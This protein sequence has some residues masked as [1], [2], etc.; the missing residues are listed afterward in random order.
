MRMFVLLSLMG[1]KLSRTQTFWR[2]LPRHACGLYWSGR[3]PAT[4]VHQQ[5]Q[6][7]PLRQVYPV[8]CLVMGSSHDSDSCCC[9]TALCLT[10]A[11][12]TDV[13]CSLLGTPRIWELWRFLLAICF[14]SSTVRDLSSSYAYILLSNILIKCIHCIIHLSNLFPAL[15]L[16]LYLLCL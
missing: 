3:G 8:M 2:A 7:Q 10:H 12:L 6:D 15:C 9:C 14:V 11:M 16:M 1:C 5:D 13:L 4:R